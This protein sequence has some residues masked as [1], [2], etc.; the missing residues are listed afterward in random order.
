[1]RFSPVSRDQRLYRKTLC[2]LIPLL[3]SLLMAC[4]HADNDNADHPSY[5]Q[6]VLQKVDLLG[7]GQMAVAIHILDSVYTHFPNPGPMDLVWKYRYLLDYYWTRQR[8][9]VRGRI[10]ADSIL[11]ILA[12]KT[13]R[14]GYAVEYGK[15]LM[16]L[17]DIC[18]EEG[19]LDNAIS[20]YYESRTFI[21][22][23]K[24]TCALGEYSARLAMVYYRQKKYNLAI[25]YFKDAF[26]EL[27]ACRENAFYRFCCQQAELDNIALG[28]DRLNENDSA[29]FYYDSALRY[30]QL[31]KTPFLKVPN[32]ATFSLAAEAVV[33]GNK[34]SLLIRKGD[35]VTGE[36]LLKKSIALNLLPGTE[37]RDAQVN[38]GKLAKMLLT[39][40]RFPEAAAWLQ[41]MRTALD[42]LPDNVSELSWRELQS[43]YDEA[44]GKPYEALLLL[45]SYQHMRDSLA[46]MNDPFHAVDINTQFNY[47][48]GEIE[49]ALLKKQNEIKNIYLS[50]MMLLTGMVVII[51]VL[52]WQYWKRSKKQAVKLE[53]LNRVISRQ[54]EH[55]EKSLRSLEQSQQ[56][57]TS[58]LK[59]VAH[60]LR[61]P[62]GNMI[63]MADFLQN[64]G[65]VTDA[66]NSEALH[67]IQQSGHMA[68]ELIS[69]LL[70]MNMRGDIRKEQ[71]EVD[72]ALRYC[73]DLIKTK[74]S[75][76]QQQIIVH[77]FHATIW[78]SREKIWRVFSNLI[79]NAVKFSPVGGIVEV[80]MQ[81]E[82]AVVRITVRDNG[83]GIP[84]FLK[85]SI[86][87]L[88]Q[89]IKRRGTM[90][91]E[92]FGFGLAISKQ[93]VDAHG[94]R[95]WF[96]S[97]EG[98]GTE[99][100]VELEKYN[101]VNHH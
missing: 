10:Y 25:P 62:V 88:S 21:Q 71:V 65:N 74:A 23:T 30:I 99:F 56:D 27:G 19:K 18:S 24:D 100:V 15:A 64:Y 31:N 93:I 45:Q 83:I 79:T 70:Y 40:K 2:W 29:S 33:L 28:F 42:S 54:N 75:E 26:T 11:R 5:F 49:L 36:T 47:L 85:G 91:E 101:E 35:T 94:G 57:N 68:L 44:T 38:M 52:I 51:V 58:M 13:E 82:D 77:L 86:F 37:P 7:P 4:N 8:D 41:K 22:R 59:I 60:D 98:K 55:L 90:G 48:S 17:G 9:R 76:K 66:Q 3:F 14:P 32:R 80:S 92:S 43:K 39:Q 72:V 84:D 63:S 50:V 78:A 67:L 97:E 96:E 46:T 87:N 69:N 20:L 61:N 16:F 95:I 81:L 89:D 6:P 12:G 34:G 53:S 73:V 1:M